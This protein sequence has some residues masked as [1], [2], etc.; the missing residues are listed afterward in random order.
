[1]M[2]SLFEKNLEAFEKSLQKILLLSF[3]YYDGGKEEKFYHNLILG[4]IL[5]LDRRYKVCSNKEIGLGRYDIVLEPKH[6]KDTA[7]IFEFKVAKAREGL[8]EKAKEALKQIK[9][10]KY[11]VDLKAKGYNILY[12]GMAFCGKEVK[13]KYL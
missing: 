11:D 4:M 10:Q 1:M 12:V 13:V 5:Y 9:E 8:E 3:S 7:Y 6:G 2:I